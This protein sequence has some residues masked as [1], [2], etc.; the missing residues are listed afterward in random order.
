LNEIYFCFEDTSFVLTSP[1]PHI[2]WISSFINDHK[3]RCGALTF[4]F[5]SDTYLLSINKEHLNH[6]Y[7]TDIITFDYVDGDVVSGDVFI[8]IDR[9]KENSKK[10]HSSFAEELRRVMA[11]GVLHLMGFSDKSDSEQERMRNEENRCLKLYKQL[12]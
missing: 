8:S 3:H 11:H 6:D 9:V 10:F 7:F 4:I 1:A 5:C 2:D 12:K